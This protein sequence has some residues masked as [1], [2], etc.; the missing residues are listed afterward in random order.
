VRIYV[1]LDSSLGERIAT[2]S[3]DMTELE[4]P[5]LPPH[6]TLLCH[7]GELPLNGGDYSLSL[8][9]KAQG[10]SADQITDA[11]SFSV[12]ATQ[13]YPTRRHPPLQGGALLVDGRW[14]L[15]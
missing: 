15:P 3:T 11:L 5:S 13:F 2:F 10:L 4:L 7:L 1:F 6:G 8:T 9:A 12:D 14:E